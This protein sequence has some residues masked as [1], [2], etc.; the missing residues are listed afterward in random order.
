M[1]F[2]LINLVT[3]IL[4]LAG[5]ASAQ[6]KRPLHPGE[7]VGPPPAGVM[8]ERL[9][10]MTPEQRKRVLGKL[11]PERRERVERRLEDYNALAPEVRHQLREQ[12]QQFQKLPPER[13]QA[14]RRSFRQFQ[15]LPDD[16]RPMVR[17]ELMRL[18]QMSPEERA[19]HVDSENFRSRF[20]ES[21]R[22][23]LQELSVPVVPKQPD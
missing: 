16:R 19:A 8:I 3:G 11:S 22:Q 15:D 13:Q 7:R 20:N 14:V 12:Y 17:R 4:L 23:V 2:F 21:E 5:S 6:P 18:R 1:R 10:S 9:N